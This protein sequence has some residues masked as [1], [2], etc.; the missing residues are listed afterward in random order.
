MPY[1]CRPYDMVFSR[2]KI[3]IGVTYKKGVDMNQPDLGIKVIELRKQRSLTQERLAELCE[4]NIR[5]IQRIE[6]GEVDP[7]SYTL[8]LLSKALEFDFE[9][10]NFSNE[11]LL[12]ALLH[13]S[14]ILCNMLIPLNILIPLLLWSWKKKYSAKIDKQGQQVLNF[15]IT[16]TLFIFAAAILMMLILIPLSA[17]AMQSVGLNVAASS[18]MV[19]LSPVPLIIIAIF[20]FFQGAINTM[21]ALTDK[22][23]RYL[24]SIPFIR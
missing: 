10:D 24:L 19:I 21:R 2:L 13:L 1:K 7:R 20:S 9:K 15:Q 4:I 23:T 22:P 16:M 8:Q 3:I 12:I 5:T 17:R 6:S 18:P 14:C 11:N